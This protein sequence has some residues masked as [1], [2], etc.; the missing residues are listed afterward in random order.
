M[1]GPVWHGDGSC[2]WAALVNHDVMLVSSLS[3][4]SGTVSMAVMFGGKKRRHS[5]C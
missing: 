4:G 1:G 5:L 2:T 3:I